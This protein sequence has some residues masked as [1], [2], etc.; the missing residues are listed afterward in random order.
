MQLSRAFIQFVA[1]TLAFFRQWVVNNFVC[2]QCFLKRIVWVPLLPSWI[3]F[4]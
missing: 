1:T 2:L 4:L 3:I